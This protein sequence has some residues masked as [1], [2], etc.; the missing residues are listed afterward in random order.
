MESP[1]LHIDLAMPQGWH[2]LSDAQLRY[3]FGLIARFSTKNYASMMNL[4]EFFADNL[5]RDFTGIVANALNDR[6]FRESLTH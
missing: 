3:A 4:K 5:G 2:E 6:S 1:V